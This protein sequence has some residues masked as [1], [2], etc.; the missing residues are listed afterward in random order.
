MKKIIA[1]AGLAIILTG[2]YNDKYNKL[3]P[4]T[5]TAVTCDTTAVSFSST[6]QPIL[7]SYCT[8]CHA[9]GGVGA[10]YGDFTSYT[11]SL[12]SQATSGNLVT[13]I[14]ITNT[15]DIHHMPQSQPSL[16]SCDIE[17]I[18]AW[19]NQGAQNN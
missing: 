8:S 3:Y 19:V 11:T 15:G 14:S 18:T 9:T 17:K 12:V 4:A 6:I 10:G 1:F 7:N 5:S 2:C 13:D 16:S